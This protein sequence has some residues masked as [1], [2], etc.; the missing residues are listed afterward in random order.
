MRLQEGTILDPE[1]EI[2]GI[3]Q[4]VSTVEL[5]LQ[6]KQLALD[7]QLNN[8]RPNQAKV[9]ALTSEIEVLSAELS[10][11]KARLNQATEGESSLASQTSDI[12]MAQAGSGHRRSWSCR[13]HWN[14]NG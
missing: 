7:I 12:Q 1:G 8:A 5:Q 6:E 10:K 9:D 14:P 3:R 4:L 11:Q 2:A 13:R